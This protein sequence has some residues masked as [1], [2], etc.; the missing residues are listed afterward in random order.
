MNTVVF[1]LLQIK[2]R[3]FFGTRADGINVKILKQSLLFQQYS[4]NYIQFMFP[5]K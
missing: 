4:K 1:N 5:E 2:R 3:T